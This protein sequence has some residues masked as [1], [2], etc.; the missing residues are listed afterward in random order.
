M[1]DAIPVPHTA[2]ADETLN[3]LI[4]EFVTRSGTDYGPE[5]ASLVRRIADVRRQLER[6]EAVIVFDPDTDTTNIVP[7]DH[8]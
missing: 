1:A 7:R 6:G 8:R 5:E 4:E 3:A 2:L